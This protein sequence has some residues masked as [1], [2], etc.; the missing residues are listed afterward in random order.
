MADG[1]FQICETYRIKLYS[2][3]FTV[4]LNW[5]VRVN[6]FHAPYKYLFLY[7]LL[8]DCEVKIV[9]LLILINVAICGN[10]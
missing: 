3:N 6:I 7:E 10:T 5:S 1:E 2:Q 8:K 4:V 9:H